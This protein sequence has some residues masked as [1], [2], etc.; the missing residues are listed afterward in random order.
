MPCV[1]YLQ[2]G[3]NSRALDGGRDLFDVTRDIDERAFTEIETAH[4]QTAN[5][6][7]QLDHMPHSLFRRKQVGSS[8]RGI[9]G[10]VAWYEPCTRSSR[11][12]DD[13]IGAAFPYALD[14]LSV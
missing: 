5:F 14:D 7:P 2:F 6:R 11:Q 9:F 1:E 3:F 12:I 10:I 13:D 8:F 4:I